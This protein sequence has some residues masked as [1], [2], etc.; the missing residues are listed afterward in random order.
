M[1]VS[2]QFQDPVRHI[3]QKIPVMGNG[4][5]DPVKGIQIILQDRERGD[6]QVVARLIEQKD[7]GILRQH[8]QQIQPALLSS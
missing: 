4:D 3:I 8:A 6:V 1:P 2:V 5:H 7:I